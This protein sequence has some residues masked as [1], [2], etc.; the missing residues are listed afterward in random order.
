MGHERF[1]ELEGAHV[2]GA[3]PEERGEFE[4]YLAVRP[5]RQAEVDELGASPKR[6]RCSQTNTSRLRSC[7]TGLWAW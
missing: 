7:A 3:L 1:E 4:R 6:W 2:L 5:E